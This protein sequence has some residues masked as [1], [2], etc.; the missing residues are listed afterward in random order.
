MCAPTGGLPVNETFAGTGCRTSASPVIGPSPCTSR[1][2][3]SGSPASRRQSASATAVSG[4]SSAGLSTT[5]LPAAKRRRHLVRDEIEGKVERR[6]RRHDAQ[7]R[8]QV[9]ADAVL[10]EGDASIGTVSPWMR[11]ASSA[12]KVNVS[13]LRATSPTA[14]FHALP[15]SRAMVSRAPRAGLD[16]FR[17]AAQHAR[18]PVRRRRAPRRKRARGVTDGKVHVAQRGDRHPADPLAGEL[19]GDL[20]QWTSILP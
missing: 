15:A 1:S 12:A 13:T 20:Q 8:A 19:V 17:R 4:V 10:A 16:Q 5:V 14:C 2:T 7:R 3:P 18:P 9:E 6:D 11:L